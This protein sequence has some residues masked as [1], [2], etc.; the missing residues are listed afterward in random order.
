MFTV[1]NTGNVE[2]T[3]VKVS[4]PM[5]NDLGIEIILEKTTLQPGESTTGTAE[6][7]ITASDV[8][9]GK[10]YNAASTTGTP[11]DDDDPNTPPL[12]PPTNNDDD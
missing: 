4:D 11:T 3:D 1:I 7:T 5:L 9:A 8:I 12:T 6:Y 10:V 2:L